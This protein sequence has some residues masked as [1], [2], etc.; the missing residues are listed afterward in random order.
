MK[1]HILSICLAAC[2]LLTGC[3]EKALSASSAPSAPSL[4]AASADGAPAGRLTFLSDNPDGFSRGTEGEQGFY[5]VVESDDYSHANLRF[6]D[7]ASGQDIVLCSS[8]SC[9]HDTDACP[10]YFPAT[11]SLAYTSGRLVLLFGSY[12]SETE[13][14]PAHI[15]VMEPDGSGRRTVYT[16]A[17]NQEL[18]G[19]IAGDGENIYFLLAT[20]EGDSP[21]SIA[22]LNLSDGSLS[23]LCK[24]DNSTFLVGAACGKLM[25]KT[26]GGD[27]DTGAA[28]PDDFYRQKHILKAVD[29]ATGEITPVLDWVQDEYWALVADDSLF[30]LSS[31]EG[32][33]HLTVRDLASGSDSEYDPDLSV[34]EGGYVMSPSWHDGILLFDLYGGP[35]GDGNVHR[36]AYTLGTG[37]LREI[38]LCDPVRGYPFQVAGSLGDKLVLQVPRYSGSDLYSFERYEYVVCSRE[39]YLASRLPQ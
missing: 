39:D 36:W 33:L 26:I 32:K 15:D 16:F 35:G 7:K 5:Y 17:A 20:F 1:K 37:E 34:A 29:P 22:R 14:L 28:S 6:I 12:Q 23:D 9:T 11:P 38:T 3:G 10:A 31:R 2:L 24:V 18:G 25:V 13:S 8:P 27:S 4:P 19:S 21:M 30:L